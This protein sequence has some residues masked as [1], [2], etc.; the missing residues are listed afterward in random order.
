[1]C[2]FYLLKVCRTL[3]NRIEETVSEDSSP[4][5]NT[6][7]LSN[8][9]QV[10]WAHNKFMTSSNAETMFCKLSTASHVAKEIAQKLEI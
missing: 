9:Q 3:Q 8:L 7:I 1:M 2:K 10:F 5:A 6:S 4:F